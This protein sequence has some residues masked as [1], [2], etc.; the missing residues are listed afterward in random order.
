M[1]W[2]YLYA[3][4]RLEYQW[5]EKY[6]KMTYFVFIW[7]SILISLLLWNTEINW[8][9]FLFFLASIWFLWVLTLVI[10]IK[11]LLNIS[12]HWLVYRCFFR[13]N[14]KLFDEIENNLDE[15]WW[16]NNYCIV[17]YWFFQSWF[18]FLIHFLLTFIIQSSYSWDTKIF[19]TFLLNFSNSMLILVLIWTLIA[20]LFSIF[21]VLF[22]YDKTEKEL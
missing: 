14:Q 19:W 8:T 4:I 2:S 21:K 16:I 7:I 10:L 15:S 11:M 22:D 1:F 18:L 12:K 9:I 20:S 6:M 5:I 13:R 17:F 3:F